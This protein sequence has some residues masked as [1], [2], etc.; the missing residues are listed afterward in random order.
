VRNASCPAAHRPLE[1]P[2]APVP[3]ARATTDEDVR[4]IVAAVVDQLRCILEDH[5]QAQ[6]SKLQEVT[7]RVPK[8]RTQSE[9]R[10]ETPFSSDQL[11]CKAPEISSVQAVECAIA[12]Q[13]VRQISC[14]SAGPSPPSS[15]SGKLR[16]QGRLQKQQLQ[17]P[18]LP[19]QCAAN[20]P[21]IATPTQ[22]TCVLP[23]Q[24]VAGCVSSTAVA[25]PQNPSSSSAIG[26]V[27]KGHVLRGD[28]GSQCVISDSPSSVKSSHV[29]P[30]RGVVLHSLESVR[31]DSKS[32]GGVG[33]RVSH[34][35]RHFVGRPTRLATRRSSRSITE[36][37][38]QGVRTGREAELTSS[39]SIGL[40]KDGADIPHPPPGSVN[41]TYDADEHE[42]WRVASPGY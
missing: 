11:P 25:V 42:E 31:T 13:L 3:C 7:P 27:G 33:Y 1:L 5:L 22:F 37:S 17:Q 18:Q 4:V 23:G 14:Q 40:Q 12:D 41:V 21:E 6:V 20:G 19:H 24:E 8:L 36:F 9:G 32:S 30:R 2:C 26:D 34:L 10:R 16:K 15:C 28:P 35:L 38:E 29:H 39:L